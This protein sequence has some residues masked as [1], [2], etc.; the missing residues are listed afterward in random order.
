MADGGGD[1]R[2]E[3]TEDVASVAPTVDANLLGELL[4]RYAGTNYARFALVARDGADGMAAGLV[5]STS[6]GWLL[7]NALWVR[8]DRRGAG[9]G[10]AMMAAAEREG[11]TRGC[12]GA[13]LD[14][15]SEGA[16]RFYERLGY[17][18]FG[19]LRNGPGRPPE[20]HARWFLS[21][22]LA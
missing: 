9:L 13:W 19:A 11:R 3:I 10:R 15:S 7:V 16:R 4:S 18:A 17:G 1:W 6:Y 20:A 21:K 14:T 22:D 12:H 2:I 5:A 8:P